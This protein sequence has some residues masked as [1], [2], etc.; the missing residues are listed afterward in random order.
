MLYSAWVFL[1]YV[2]FYSNEVADICLEIFHM[3]LFDLCRT[4]NFSELS[5]KIV[6]AYLIDYFE[7]SVAFRII[8]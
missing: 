3:L 1:L 6:P 2:E 7:Y 8:F 5:K 4:C